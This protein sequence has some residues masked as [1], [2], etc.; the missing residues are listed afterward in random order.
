MNYNKIS[1]IDIMKGIGCCIFD[2]AAILAY[3]QIFGLFLIVAPVKS[4]LILLVLFAGLISINGAVIFPSMIFKSIGVPYS[5]AISTFFVLY[6]MISNIASVFLIPTSTIWYLA[7]ELMIFAIFVIMISVVVSFSKASEKELIINKRENEEKTS[8]I[9][10][11]QEIEA[12]INED[13]KAILPCI[14]SFNL[15]KERIKASTPFG[16]INDNIA[17]LEIEN[18]IK[19]NLLSIKDGFQESLTDENIN[20]LQKLIE[21]TRKLVINRET[22]NIK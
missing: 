13:Q 2:F 16:R 6:A 19:S 10:Q 1:S 15:L 17:V 8:I 18:Q 14:N 20:K 5:A 3:F 22:L 11:L 21:D 9:L 7:C 12:S 4:V